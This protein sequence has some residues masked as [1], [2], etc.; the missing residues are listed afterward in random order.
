M[1][2][3]LQGKPVAG[4]ILTELKSKIISSEQLNHIPKLAIIR[5]GENA[6]DL[7]YEHSIQTTCQTIGMD[8]QVFEYKNNI[9]QQA[10]EH[11][12]YTITNKST[13]HG[14][15]ILVPLPLFFNSQRVRKLIP[16]SKDVDGLNPQTGGNFYM[17][18]H[19]AFVPCTA[20]ACLALLNFYNIELAG[21]HCVIINRSLT[22]GKPL[23]LLLLDKNATVTICHSKTRQLAQLCQRADILITATGQPK[24]ITPEFTHRAQI[25]L[26]IGINHDPA[27][28]GRYCGDVDFEKVAPLVKKITPVPGGIGAITT[29]VLCQHTFFA[30]TQ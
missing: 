30:A 28:P 13:I 2:N 27:S 22:V 17:G 29:A 8:C 21:R 4:A 25:I 1:V 12:V 26:D 18:D 5:V 14:V 23:S 24:I 19:K 3:L 15:L 6:D 11:A 20:Q 7:Y 9:T 10:L 16:P